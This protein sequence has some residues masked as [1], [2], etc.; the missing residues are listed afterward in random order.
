[1]SDEDQTLATNTFAF[2]SMEGRLHLAVAPDLV[3][4]RASRTICGEVLRDEKLIRVPPAD[5]PSLH[6]F[7]ICPNC[8]ALFLHGGYREFALSLTSQYPI[9]ISDKQG[10]SHRRAGKNQLSLF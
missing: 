8:S 5:I 4:L 9:T 6:T 2:V 10:S 3:V 7:A 1:M